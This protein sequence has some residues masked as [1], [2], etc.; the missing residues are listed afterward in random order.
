MTSRVCMLRH[1]IIATAYFYP[2]TLQYPLPRCKLNKRLITVRK[3]SCG[4][5]MFVHL[6][7]I[8]STGGVCR[9]PSRRQTPPRQTSP[10]QTPLPGK[11]SP[12]QTPPPP[13]RP[14]QPKVRI[15]LEC[16]LVADAYNPLARQICISSIW[17][18]LTV[19]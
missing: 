9:H 12:W 19:T 16:I 15:L 10:R 5:V 6:S 18:C 11:I 14:L 7:V 3:R 17:W 1:V 8:L 2:F 4:K 13:R